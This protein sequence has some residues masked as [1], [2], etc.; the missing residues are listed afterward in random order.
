MD[1]EVDFL[2]GRFVSPDQVRQNENTHSAA[3][4]IHSSKKHHSCKVRLP[5]F[6]NKALWETYFIITLIDSTILSSQ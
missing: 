5:I 4:F 3:S 1:N 6:L 2:T